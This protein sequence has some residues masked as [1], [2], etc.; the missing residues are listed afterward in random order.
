MDESFDSIEFNKSLDQAGA[1]KIDLMAET[2]QPARAADDAFIRALYAEHGDAMLRYAL[3]LCDGDRRRAEDLVQETIVRAWRHPEAIADRPP[4]PWL[5]AVM[6][7]LAIHAYRARQSRA[8]E[9]PG[10]P[11]PEENESSE[12]PTASVLMGTGRNRKTARLDVKPFLKAFAD[13]VGSTFGLFNEV[14]RP[15]DIMAEF[16]NDLA[17]EARRITQSL[18]LSPEGRRDEGEANS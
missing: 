15:S 16:E 13:G 5:F 12:K 10:D 17:I 9:D 4:R 1:T 8:P 2:T 11:E 18:G 6:R 3:H 14:R 7:N